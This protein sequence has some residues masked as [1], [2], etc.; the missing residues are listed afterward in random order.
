MFQVATVVAA[1]CTVAVA[2]LSFN[3]PIQLKLS[4]ALEAHSKSQGNNFLTVI[5][6]F[7]ILS[8]N[9]VQIRHGLIFV[10]KSTQNLCYW[11][12]DGPRD[13]LVHQ[14]IVMK[15]GPLFKKAKFG[16][17]SVVCNVQWR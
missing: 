14:K 10:P 4:I 16:I 17:V 5:K 1:K 13:Q 3:K 7:I 8:K 9:F 15:G 6:K 11:C 12:H 2:V